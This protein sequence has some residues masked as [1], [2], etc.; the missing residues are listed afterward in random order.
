VTI[1]TDTGLTVG[2][3]YCY[4]VRAINNSGVSPYSN[5]NDGAAKPSPTCGTVKTVTPDGTVTYTWVCH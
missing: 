2:Q 1:Y 5:Q 4:K 3:V